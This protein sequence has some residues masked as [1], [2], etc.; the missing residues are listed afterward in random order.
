MLNNIRIV[1]V[2]PSHS[3]NVGSVARAMKTM[4]LAQLVLV[5][6]SCTLDEQ[7][8]ALAAG[9]KDVLEQVKIVA[10]FDEAIGDCSLVMGSSARLRH[11][12]STLVTP[13]EGAQLTINELSKYE[14]SAVALVF[15]RERVGLTNEELLKCHY[16]VNI[17]ANPDYASLN[18]AMA[19]QLVCYEVRMAY[20]SATHKALKTRL[21]SAGYASVSEVEHLL[22][23]SER[24]YRTLGFIQNE[25][26]MEKLRRL[27]NRARLEK[28]EVNILQGIL[29]A[30][31]K[32]IK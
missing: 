11:L 1:L 30:V 29:S 15:G 3:G 16:H 6:P 18:L 20:L 19:V 10:S 17:P 4:G 8:F 22:A 23:H 24:T 25:A 21:S 13:R 2:A 26:V 12:Q 31:D 7:A 28:N 9:A 27:Y 5:N 14:Q 32:R